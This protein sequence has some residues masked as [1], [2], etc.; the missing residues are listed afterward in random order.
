MN[1]MRNF[2]MYY[3]ESSMVEWVQ[4][5]CHLVKHLLCSTSV[6]EL[7]SMESQWKRLHRSKDHKEKSELHS[8]IEQPQKEKQKLTVWFDATDCNGIQKVIMQQF[9][10]IAQ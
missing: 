3:F 1:V 10:E 8:I 6:R 9:A 7:S 5:L 4:F 2:P